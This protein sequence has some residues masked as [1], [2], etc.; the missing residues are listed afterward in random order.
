MKIELTPSTPNTAAGQSSGISSTAL[1]IPTDGPREQ[2][3]LDV[4]A[5]EQASKLSSIGFPP[6]NNLN[7]AEYRN[8]VKTVVC[9]VKTITWG[10]ASCKV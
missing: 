9:G 10:C 8:L 5:S 7:V 1:S 3:G 4:S 2:L 6:P